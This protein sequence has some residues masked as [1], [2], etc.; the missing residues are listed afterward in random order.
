MI[1][2]I[3]RSSVLPHISSMPKGK[4]YP[5]A[6]QVTTRKKGQGTEKGECEEQNKNRKM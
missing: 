5:G 2:G 4:R 3:R 6:H 1:L